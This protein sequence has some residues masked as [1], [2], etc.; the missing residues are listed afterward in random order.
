MSGQTENR[1]YKH[2]QRMSC[3][4]KQDH[5]LQIGSMMPLPIDTKKEYLAAEPD[6]PVEEARRVMF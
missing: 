3:H 6:L 5:G 4:P 1:H 2:K